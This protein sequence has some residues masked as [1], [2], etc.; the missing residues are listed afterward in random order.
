[1][2]SVFF[3]LAKRSRSFRNS[4]A[5]SFADRTPSMTCCANS[6]FVTEASKVDGSAVFAT[7]AFCDGFLFFA[8][9]SGLHLLILEISG[10]G[11]LVG[12]S[13]KDDKCGN[14]KKIDRG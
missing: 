11:D 7:A 3:S 1:M 12:N 13:A 9:F 6:S 4:S 2:F 5:V 10:F 14:R 8:I